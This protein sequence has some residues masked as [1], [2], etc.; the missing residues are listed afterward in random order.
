MHRNTIAG[1]RRH[2]DESP[3]CRQRFVD[4]RP[5]I[6]RQDLF[7]IEVRKF[8]IHSVIELPRF[9]DCPGT[10]R[11]RCWPAHKGTLLINA[12][13]FRRRHDGSW[14]LQTAFSRRENQWVEFFHPP[15]YPGIASAGFRYN[16]RKRI[17]PL[18]LLMIRSSST[19]SFSP[20]ILRWEST[21]VTCRLILIAVADMQKVILFAIRT[22]A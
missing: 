3:G 21:S 13:G 11:P 14:H 2:G 10:H 1:S 16:D 18:L 5:P 19:H 20:L 12:P 8:E 15:A 6:V 17:F 4:I 9:R 22:V 7:W